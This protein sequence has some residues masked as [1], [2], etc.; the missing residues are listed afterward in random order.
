MLLLDVFESIKYQLDK[1]GN[2]GKRK[3]Q[4]IEI[5]GNMQKAKKAE[6]GKEGKIKN[7]KESLGFQNWLKIITTIEVRVAKCAPEVSTYNSFT[8]LFPFI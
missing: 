7:D 8:V 3:S 5:C 6:K 4:N 2:E 1:S